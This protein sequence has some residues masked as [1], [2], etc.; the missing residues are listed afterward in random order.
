MTNSRLK[1]SIAAATSAALAAL[2]ILFI[3]SALNI[4]AFGGTRPYTREVVGAF[5][6]PLIPSAVIAVGLIAAGFVLSGL[7]KEK[8]EDD[9]AKRGPYERLAD[10]VRRF[11]GCELPAAQNTAIRKERR[12]RRN[13]NILFF[14]IS[15]LLSAAAFIYVIF[16]AEL[17]VSELNKNVMLAFAVSLP[18]LISAVGIHI[19]RAFLLNK[20][21]ERELAALKECIR[22]GVRISAPVSPREYRRE[23]I[24][25]LSAGLCV[26]AVAVT[27]IVLGI[28]NGG[29]EDVL[30]KAVK[31]CT[32]C[33]GL[34]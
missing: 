17:T 30:A 19:L 27:F 2:G 14:S 23:G 24:L 34:G 21:A 20:S 16:F 22:K 11:E 4:A 18:L 10:Y 15:L 3:I 31:I 29:M 25:R 7:S 1:R 13:V 32:E 8:N 26:L 6:L 28:F 9:K 5:L 12:Y 33:I